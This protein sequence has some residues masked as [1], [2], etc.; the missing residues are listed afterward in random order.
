[1]VRQQQLACRVETATLADTTCTN[2]GVPYYSETVMETM[3][4][5]NIDQPCM[6][7]VGVCVC[8][9]KGATGA[10]SHGRGLGSAE[11]GIEG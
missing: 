5:D 1:M 3:E 11:G 7:F 2:S 9:V 10:A 4:K 6:V 8:V